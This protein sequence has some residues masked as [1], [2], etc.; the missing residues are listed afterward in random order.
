MT[1][2]KDGNKRRIIVDLS[3]T[4][5]QTY[6]VNTT[7]SKT[8]Y[9]GTPFSLKLPT[10]DSICQVLNVLGKNVK[11]FK[12]DLARAFRQLH[13]DP[14][15]IK[16]LGLY[17]RGAYYVD[18]AMPFGY[19]HGTQACVRVTDAIRYIL[20]RMGVFVLN[21]IDDIIGIAPDNVA[22]VHFK[23]TLNLFNKLGFLISS[24]KTI[25]PTS[26]AT[27]LG[28]VFN[29]QIGVLQIPS[30]KL[31]EIVSLCKH[32]FSKKFITK[33]QLQALIGSLIFLHKAIKPARTFVN[34]IL[35]LLR[36]MGTATKIAI[37]EATKQDLQWFI[38]CAHSVNGS[39]KI[40]KCL[41][42]RT[43]IFVDASLRGLG[44][45]L[46][47]FIYKL[48][49]PPRPGWCIAHW[50]A[51]N[52]L[53]ALRTFSNFIQ[54]KNVTIWCDNQV[55]INIL[56]SGRGVD[57]ILQN[58]SR[59]I[60]LFSSQWDC[61]IQFTHIKGENNII[62]DML[63]RWESYLNPHSHL[64]QLLNNLPLWQVP[65]CDCLYLDASI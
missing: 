22:D 41:Q 30:I 53:V 17:W 4:S 56:N 23:I 18:T 27:C 32:Y 24:S 58:I 60:W 35:A 57:P 64:F 9:V 47:N 52:I 15:D 29:I 50:E 6:A 51:I 61:D 44:G 63:S 26:V 11:I 13:V 21:Y 33:N 12:I 36:K 34:R 16:Y 45:V 10:V 31:Q 42:P 38:A 5:G 40:Y 43:D 7:V 8:H 1:A 28:I 59:N 25:P 14:F 49:L 48:A 3:F 65:P 37:D 39:V 55:A 19:R 54:G 62:A 46:K 2:P 20:S